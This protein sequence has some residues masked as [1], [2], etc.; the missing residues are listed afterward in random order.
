M[1]M[2]VNDGLHYR[3][4]STEIR[5]G[6]IVNVRR[7]LFFWRRTPGIVCYMPGQSAPH[8][9]MEYEGVR[10]WSI[11][12]EDGTLVSWVF[13][14]TEVLPSKRIEFVRR[15]DLSEKALLPTEHLKWDGQ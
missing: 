14:P 7:L 11:Q 8:P 15:G 6:D 3:G 13:L 5:L 12:L 4:I 1:A 2:Q 10:Y 9:Q